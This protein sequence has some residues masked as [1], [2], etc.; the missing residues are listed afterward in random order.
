MIQFKYTVKSLLA[1]LNIHSD[2]RPNNEANISYIGI[3]TQFNSNSIIQ[4][5]CNIYSILRKCT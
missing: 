5:T 1:I 4:L 3:I 2:F